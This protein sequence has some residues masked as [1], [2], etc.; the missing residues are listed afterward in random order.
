MQNISQK[1]IYSKKRLGNR[2]FFEIISKYLEQ[3]FYGIPMNS[4]HH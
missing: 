4:S 1:V 3:L 2:Y